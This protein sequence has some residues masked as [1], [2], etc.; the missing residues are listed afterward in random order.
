M[1]YVQATP[2]VV[3]DMMFVTLPPNEVYALDARTG[4]QLWSYTG[5]ERP[6]LRVTGNGGAVNRGVAILGKTVFFGSADAHLVALSAQ[7]G[8]VLW[9]VKVAENSDG[10]FIT[11]APLAIKDKIVLGVAGGEFAARLRRRALTC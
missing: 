2:L 3:G 5:P 8:R 1:R 4:K 7:D 11:G 10:Y 9:D 6:N